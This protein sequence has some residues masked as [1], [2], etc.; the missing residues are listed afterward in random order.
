MSGKAVHIAITGIMLAAVVLSIWMTIRMGKIAH[1]G[2]DTID[3][4]EAIW[5]TILFILISFGVLAAVVMLWYT[6]RHSPT[7][8]LKQKFGL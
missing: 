6:K 5:Y 7:A 8:R 4:K 1:D 2:G 3:K